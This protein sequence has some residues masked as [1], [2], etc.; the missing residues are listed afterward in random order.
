MWAGVLAAAMGGGSL[1]LLVIAFMGLRALYRRG[2]ASMYGA[3]DRAVSEGKLS[4]SNGVPTDANPYCGQDEKLRDAWNIG[5]KCA[6][7]DREKL[8]KR[9]G[10]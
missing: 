1:A 3:R 9:I 10:R 2:Y 7:R 6:E 8:V 4:Y 5:W